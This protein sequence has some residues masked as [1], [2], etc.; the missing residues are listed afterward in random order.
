MRAA[1]ITTSTEMKIT[2]QEK[3]PNND[4]EAFLE[5]GVMGKHSKSVITIMIFLGGLFCKLK[6]CGCARDRGGTAYF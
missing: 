2:R 5:C 1:R 6:A 3:L 4:L